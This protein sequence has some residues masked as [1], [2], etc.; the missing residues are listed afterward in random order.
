MIK[1]PN[2]VSIK[3]YIFTTEP[4][5]KTHAGILLAESYE[6]GNMIIL[7]RIYEDLTDLEIDLA[8]AQHREK[9][10]IIILDWGKLYEDSVPNKER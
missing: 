6:D 8:V 9:Y 1:M 5:Y 10:P 3:S 2:I 7:E 4:S